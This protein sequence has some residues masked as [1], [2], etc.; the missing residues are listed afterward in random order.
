MH[1]QKNGKDTSGSDGHLDTEAG[2]TGSDLDSGGSAGGLGRESRGAQ[3]SQGAQAWKA[4]Q[5][6]QGQRRL[7]G[8]G[9]VR[10]V[11][12]LRTTLGDGVNLGGVDSLGGVESAVAG[13][14][15]AGR[16]G[17]V[18][19]SDGSVTGRLGGVLLGDGADGGRD[20]D[21]LGGDG[22]VRAVL[23]GGRALGDG[24][25]GGA[26][27]GLGGVLLGRVTSRLGVLLGHRADSGRNS[28]SLGDGVRTVRTVGAVLD[29]RRALGVGVD[30]SGVDS[31]GG[32]RDGSLSGLVAVRALS[33]GAS[34]RDTSG[35][36]LGLG[37][38]GSSLSTSLG[39][40]V[41][42][43]GLSLGVNGSRLGASGSGLGLG[44]GRSSLGA[45]DSSLGLSVNG[46]GLSLSVDRS[47]LGLSV[48]GSGL[49]LG[50]DR[51]SLGLSTGGGSCDSLSG[52]TS[53]SLGLDIG[54]DTLGGGGS[55]GSSG[56][57]LSLGVDRGSLSAGRGSLGASDDGDGGR[58]SSRAGDLLGCGVT[59]LLLGGGVGLNGLSAGGSSCDSLGGHTS[60]SLGLDIG[61]DSLSRG[62]GGGSSGSSLSSGA[63]SL[64]G[65][66]SGGGRRCGNGGG[67]DLAS[68]GIN[69]SLLISTSLGNVA[70]LRGE[71]EVAGALDSQVAGVL[72]I[73]L[74]RLS[75]RVA[76]GR[77]GSQAE[78]HGDV[79]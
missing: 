19:L 33:L 22:A 77:G 30:S 52:H 34:G 23:D 18:T 15:V 61:A 40:G 27:D 53:L 36:G 69:D 39:L 14:S 31:L 16:L 63:N 58:V 76:V 35:V 24:V 65:G 49:S 48:N 37:V 75:H 28:N 46:S 68:A 64:G 67:S 32:V 71:A 44:V 73:T 43:G 11:R 2:S 42:R 4:A 41:D 70:S 59:V 66:D 7:G 45:S 3:E 51:S 50:V 1:L 5:G 20:G 62:S 57:S 10:A 72:G 29:V 6:V 12:D 60:L 78:G 8:D 9:T 56:S 47:S 79:G 13:R 54:A 55:G 26:V 17:G 21:G 38:D 74:A 25:D